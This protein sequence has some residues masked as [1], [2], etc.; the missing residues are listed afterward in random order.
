MGGLCGKEHRREGLAALPAA[1]ES[2]D[3]SERTSDPLFKLSMEKEEE[4]EGDEEEE[5]DASIGGER[6]GVFR[7]GVI[8][9][10]VFTGGLAARVLPD[11]AIRCCGATSRCCNRHCKCCC[12]CCCCCCRCGC[13]S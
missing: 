11:S 8:K 12:V 4:S 13:C 7:V 2:A 9:M 10:W 3:E 6:M 1:T 5:E